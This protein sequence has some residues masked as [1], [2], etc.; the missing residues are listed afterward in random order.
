MFELWFPELVD[1]F[2]FYSPLYSL[3]FEYLLTTWL[4]ACPLLWILFIYMLLFSWITEI[5]KQSE[6]KKKRFVSAFFFW[7][8]NYDSRKI[9]FRRIFLN[10]L[11]EFRRDIFTFFLFSPGE[12]AIFVLA[13]SR[14]WRKR[15][16]PLHS[17]LTSL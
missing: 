6:I 17:K 15:K 3:T 10:F 7:N 14:G 13:V 8:R 12:I 16:Q 2:F 9:E 5:R 4:T 1:F 11:G